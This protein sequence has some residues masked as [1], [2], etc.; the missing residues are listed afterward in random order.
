MEGDVGS[1]FIWQGIMFHK[2]ISECAMP[3]KESY[4]EMSVH[5]GETFHLKYPKM[6]VVLAHQLLLVQHHFNKHGTVVFPHTKYSLY[7]TPC[8]FYPF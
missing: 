7:L 1:L 8:D 5:L 3:N 4:K 6:W 2:F